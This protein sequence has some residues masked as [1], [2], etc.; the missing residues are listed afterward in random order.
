MQ[1][2]NEL[3]ARSL[4]YLYIYVF[5]VPNPYTEQIRPAREEGKALIVVKCVF[6]T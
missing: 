6:R 1:I 4:S 3:V 2:L 5:D